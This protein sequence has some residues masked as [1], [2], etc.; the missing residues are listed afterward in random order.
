[1]VSTPISF[2]SNLKI[3]WNIGF[4]LKSIIVAEIGHLEKRPGWYTSILLL[5]GHQDAEHHG[6][7]DSL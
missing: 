2:H 5:F 4:F 1:M 6:T 7:S 3:K